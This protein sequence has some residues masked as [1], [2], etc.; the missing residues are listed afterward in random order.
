MGGSVWYKGKAGHSE[1]SRG[2]DTSEERQASELRLR[3]FPGLASWGPVRA[4]G[5][6]EFNCPH[7]G[8]DSS[9]AP[10]KVPVGREP[11]P[12]TFRA[13][14]EK[15]GAARGPYMLGQI[16]IYSQLGMPQGPSRFM[17]RKLP[18]WEL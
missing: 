2:T 5:P 1:D 7:S 4:L 3:P 9:E 8:V 15:Q 17:S 10:P 12:K 18:A 14:T 6:Q 13:P 16:P 11:S